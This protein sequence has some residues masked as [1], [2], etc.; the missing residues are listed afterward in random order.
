MIRNRT[1]FVI[2]V[3]FT[4][5]A[6]SAA[7]ARIGGG[8]SMG[9]RGSRGSAAPRT[10]QAPRSNPGTTGSS[11]YR[12]TPAQPAQPYGYGQPAPQSGGFMRS[13]GGGLAG[14]FLG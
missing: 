4:F 2:L 13:F 6:M 11:P 9:S 8:R 3:L 1:P 10:Y 14:G 5:F 7:E 12:T